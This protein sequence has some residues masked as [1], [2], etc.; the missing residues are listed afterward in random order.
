MRILKPKV[1]LVLHEPVAACLQPAFDRVATH[2][3]NHPSVHCLKQVIQQEHSVLGDLEHA[4]ICWK[5]GTILQHLKT[6]TSA[7]N[8]T[9]IEWTLVPAAQNLV[10]QHDE[11]VGDPDV[12]LALRWHTGGLF[13]VAVKVPDPAHRSSDGIAQEEDRVPRVGHQP[14]HLE[15]GQRAVL[16][17]GALQQGSVDLED[18]GI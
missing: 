14:V 7:K 3:Q 6:S 9:N 11:R 16:G 2:P 17:N 4:V 1:V 5:G 12:A 8:L 18:T 13:R 15:P 10:Q